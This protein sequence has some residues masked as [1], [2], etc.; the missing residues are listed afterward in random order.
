MFSQFA[1]RLAVPGLAALALLSPTNAGAS[2]C[3]ESPRTAMIVPL[4]RL[5][6]PYASDQ[7]ATSIAESFRHRGY[8]VGVSGEPGHWLVRVQPFSE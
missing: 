2:E 1:H 8:H 4:A 5:Y 6:G 3:D 7:T